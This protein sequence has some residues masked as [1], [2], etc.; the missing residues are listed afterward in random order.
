MEI[1]RKWLL[2]GDYPKTNLK[3]HAM[4]ASFY[5]SDSPE[6]RLRSYMPIKGDLH[7]NS[8]YLMTIKGEGTL[9]RE[10][11]EFPISIETW[12]DCLRFIGNKDPIIK[13]YYIYSIGDNEIEVSI[14]DGGVFT[15]AEVEFSSEEE[16][17]KFVF[18][19]KNAVEVT[20]DI[21]YKMKNYWKRSREI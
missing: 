3:T 7:N 1:E 12:H 14:V 17:S 8:P 15:Y 11:I 18:P 4:V 20:D 6:V 9:V 19:W 13:D 21:S 16:A 10:E 2:I 5:I